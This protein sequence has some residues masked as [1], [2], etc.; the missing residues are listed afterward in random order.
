MDKAIIVIVPSLQKY[1]NSADPK[2]QKL[3][4]KQKEF[5]ETRP[6]HN[7]LGRTKLRNVFDKYGNQLWE[8]RLNL[9]DRIAFVERSQNCIIWLKICSHDELKR[10]NVIRV[11]D[12]Y[13]N[14]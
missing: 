7:S 12:V 2:I 6:Y 14:I 4:K 1:I 11:E 9:R 13:H 3:F 8:I 5:M 10:K